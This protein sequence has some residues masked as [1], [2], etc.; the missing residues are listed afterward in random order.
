MRDSITHNLLSYP[1]YFSATINKQKTHEL[2]E[3]PTGDTFLVND[4][5]LLEEFDPTTNKYTGR[6]CEVAVTYVSPSPKPWLVPGNTLMSTRL[7]DP[8]KW[9]EKIP[10]FTTKK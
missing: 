6:T 8:Q 2:R 1:E 9:Y 5:L 10:F 7:K 4:T 3:D